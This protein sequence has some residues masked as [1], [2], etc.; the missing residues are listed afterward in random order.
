MEKEPII[1]PGELEEAGDKQVEPE[2]LPEE[3][4]ESTQEI[5]EIM[6][7]LISNDPE[8]FKKISEMPESPEKVKAIAGIIGVTTL[9]LESNY[10]LERYSSEERPAAAGGVKSREKLDEFMRKYPG[11]LIEK[12]IE[13]KL[14]SI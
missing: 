14:K 2:E 5:E 13:E 12:A 1:K 6:D 8:R 9:K 11:N 3:S 10:G 7:K 4:M